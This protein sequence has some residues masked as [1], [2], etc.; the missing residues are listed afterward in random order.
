VGLNL[1]RR[2]VQ[3]HDGRVTAESGGAGQGSRFTIWLPLPLQGRAAAPAALAVAQPQAPTREKRKLRILVVDDNVDAA[4]ILATLLEFAGHSVTV[5][6][7]GAGALAST[8][9][10]PAQVVFL[11][12]GLPDMSG[13]D[14]APMLR[15]MHG[16]AGAKLIALTGWG[17]E[18]DK[19]RSQGAGFDYHLTK[20]AD[21]MQVETL[22]DGIAA[23]LG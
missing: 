23:Q 13:Y 21:F 10:D 3:L 16:M 19:L 22:L 11:D 6:H 17:A 4:D 15:N 14:A 7:D 2:L 9:V 1:V 8:A 18:S 20:P 5:A 12:I